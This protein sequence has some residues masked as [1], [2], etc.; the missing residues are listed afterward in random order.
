MQKR[1]LT[2]GGCACACAQGLFIAILQVAGSLQTVAD[3]K[4]LQNL[5]ICLEML[6]AALGMMFAFPYTEYKGQ[7]A[8]TAMPAWHLTFVEHA[9]L[10]SD[11]SRHLSEMR[12]LIIVVA[13][14]VCAVARV[15][16]PM[17]YGKRG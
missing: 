3:G 12:H 4:N 7:G 2:A 9:S 1:R 16:S 15:C 13:R 6:P 17:G 14:R 5:L 11:Q 10:R 8:R